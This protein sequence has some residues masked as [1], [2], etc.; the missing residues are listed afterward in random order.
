MIEILAGEQITLR[1]LHQ[2]YAQELFRLV[3][4][5]REHL[6]T[7]LPW[8]DANQTQADSEQFIEMCQQHYL[9]NG[10]IQFAINYNNQL[11]GL[12]GFHPIS[13]L[14]R[15]GA[16]GYWLAKEFCSKGIVTRATKEVIKYG[17]EHLHLNRIEIKCATQNTASN[18]V[19]QKLGLKHEGILRQA[20]WL[21]DHF[22]DHN[23]YS[24]LSNEYKK[25]ST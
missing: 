18:W 4:K 22:V 3:D 2:G 9:K 10:T 16:I 23:V 12:V 25:E 11:A 8:L 20:E 15:S 1:Q 13:T 6:R 24:V 17:F 21:Y 14:N 19:A 7:F 5:N